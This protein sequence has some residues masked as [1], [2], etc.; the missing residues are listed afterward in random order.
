MSNMSRQQTILSNLTTSKGVI[1]V[2]LEWVDE[3]LRM[4]QPIKQRAAN[5]R[6]GLVTKNKSSQLVPDLKDN[7]FWDKGESL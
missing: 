1:Y 3:L 5:E 6:R 4:Q 7:E 2:N